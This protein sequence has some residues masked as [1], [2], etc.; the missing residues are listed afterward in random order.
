MVDA[1]DL[2]SVGPQGLCRFK[3]DRPHHHYIAAMGLPEDAAGVG[4]ATVVVGTVGA[5]SATKS[6]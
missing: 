5:G 3:S 1:P 4:V 2:K 6:R